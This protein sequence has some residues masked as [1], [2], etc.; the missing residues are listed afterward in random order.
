MLWILLFILIFGR[1][2]SL[3]MIPKFDKRVKK[4]VEVEAKKKE[5]LA[6][7]KAFKKE[8]KAHQKGEKK[9]LKH[10]AANSLARNTPLEFFEISFEKMYA[11]QNKFDQISVE[12]RLKI[13]KLL[14]EDEWQ[15]IL[16]AT[17]K[18][19][20][21][22]QKNNQKALKKL[23]KVIEK[24]KKSIAK[25]LPDSKKK[26]QAISIANQLQTDINKEVNAFFKINYLEND[27]LRNIN[28]TEAEI[29]AVVDKM[30]A[31]RKN[32]FDAFVKARF[33]MVNATTEQE[34]NSIVKSI[35][36]LLKLFVK[37]DN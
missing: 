26:E 5:I 2:E 33:E 6:S 36:K 20:K 17:E 21:K 28:A 10:F 34:W 15:N 22:E 8:K 30:S 11:D 14:K 32:I 24:I 27:T 29:Q 12:E 13:Q 25:E 19:L 3:T 18:G 37:A 31:I 7:I 9:F 4:Y 1:S 23:N 16:K 35:N